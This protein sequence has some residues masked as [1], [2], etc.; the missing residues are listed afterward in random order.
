MFVENLYSLCKDNRRQE[1]LAIILDFFDDNLSIGNFDLCKETIRE[2]DPANLTS[3]SIVTIL[4][5]TNMVKDSLEPYRKIFFDKA[6]IVLTEMRGKKIAKEL[7][8]RY[9]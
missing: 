9:K 8:N 7:I 4:A 2:L 1:A 6:M 5:Y 3:S